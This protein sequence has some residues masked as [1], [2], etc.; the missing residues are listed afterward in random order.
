[1]VLQA[2]F[3]GT[4]RLPTLRDS[5]D[6]SAFGLRVGCHRFSPFSPWISTFLIIK[7]CRFVQ[8]P[9]LHPAATGITK[10]DP[11]PRIFVPLLAILFPL[12]GVRP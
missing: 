7:R 1:M 5:G 4:D 8:N 12:A 3:Q 2:R 6:L 9:D 10:I 11:R